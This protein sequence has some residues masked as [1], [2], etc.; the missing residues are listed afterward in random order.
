MS[1]KWDFMTTHCHPVKFFWQII[2]SRVGW[3]VL[4]WLVAWVENRMKLVNE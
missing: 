4:V 3:D 1:S 2:G